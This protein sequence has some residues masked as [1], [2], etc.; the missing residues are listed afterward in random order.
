MNAL[1]QRKSPRLQSY[2]YSQNGAYFVTICTQNRT[3]IFGEILN[4]EM[5]LNTLGCIAQNCWVDIPTHFPNVDCDAYVVMPNHVH[6][7]VVITTETDTIY[8][9]PTETFGRP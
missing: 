3:Q 5:A 1:P 9:V 7:I 2:D 4:G 6:G 8:R